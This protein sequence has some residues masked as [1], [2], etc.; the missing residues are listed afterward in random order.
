MLRLPTGF[1]RLIFILTAVA[2]EIPKSYYVTDWKTIEAE[3]VAY[4]GNFEIFLFE[5]GLVFG[6]GG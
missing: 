4:K 3:K 1:I 2:Y 6:A 5:I